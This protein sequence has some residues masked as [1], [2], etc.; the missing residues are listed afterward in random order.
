[1]STRGG[2]VH[3][4]WM[5]GGSTARFSARYP[6][7]IIVI[8]CHTHFYDDF[9]RKKTHFC[10]FRQFLDNSPIFMENLP[11]KVPLFEE[12]WPKNPPIWAAHTRA[13]N[14]LYTHFM[15]PPP[16]GMSSRTILNNSSLRVA[17][18]DGLNNSLNHLV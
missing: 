10:Y 16:P 8:C 4:L 9:W 7:L 12:F 18:S 13:L 11:K 3:G 1:M 14:M 15:P 6:L 5:D 2:G 17:S